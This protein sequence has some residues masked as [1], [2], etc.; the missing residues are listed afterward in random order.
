M[1]LGGEVRIFLTAV[2]GVPCGSGP[3]TPTLA[4][5]KGHADVQCSEIYSRR[6]RHPF[7]PGVTT[8]VSSNGQGKIACTIF[9]LVNVFPHLL[10]YRCD[11]LM[12]TSTQL[13]C[14]CLSH[15]TVCCL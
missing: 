4:I 3:Q 1:G 7:P 11:H 2:Q 12:S 15:L 14:A 5:Q 10:P 6:N 9:L 13:S 8:R